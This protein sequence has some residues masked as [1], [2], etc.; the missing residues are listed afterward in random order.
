[1]QYN[2]TDRLSTIRSA[3]ITKYLLQ[4]SKKKGLGGLFNPSI[5]ILSLMKILAILQKGNSK[6]ETI[7]TRND[8]HWEKK[9]DA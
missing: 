2:L 7:N 3:S 6:G 5:S 4:Y 1:M 9:H 8:I